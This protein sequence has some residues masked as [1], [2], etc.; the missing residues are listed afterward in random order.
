MI[1][2]GSHVSFKKPLYLVGASADSVANKANTMMIFLGAPQTSKRI[3]VSNYRL[4]DYQKMYSNIITPEDIVVHAP[5][6]INNASLVKAEFAN[7][8]LIEEINR[9]NYIGAKYLVLHPGSYTTF[10]RQ[11]SIEQ[12]IESL[13]FVIS[14]TKDVVICIETM[15]GKG[16]EIGTR[17][18]EIVYI[19]ESI[20]SPRVAICL[21]T[22]HVWDAGYNL[23]NYNEFIELLKSTRMINYL[24]VIHLNDSQNELGSHRDRHA[25]IDQGKIGLETLQKIVHEPL[26]DNIPIILETPWVDG[27][28]IYD[29]EIAMLLNKK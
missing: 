29:K 25:N 23:H 24:K 21:D 5:Y 6:I 17:F 8:F 13:K 14:Q 9:M 7:K 1:K 27:A 22:C 18:E 4:E 12:L 16:T 19:V 15:A 11:A 3:S 10:S 20:N 28:P 26:F 2:L